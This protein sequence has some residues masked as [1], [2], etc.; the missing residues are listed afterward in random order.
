[1]AKTVTIP[2]GDNPFICKIND[3]YY[4]YPAGAT[5]EVPDEVAALI[6][7]N[8]GNR[9]K[10]NGLSDIAIPRD[11]NVD[12][13]LT[14]TADGAAWATP[15]SGSSLPT[16]T[17]DD[18]GDVL[19]VVEGAWA[20]ASGGG[21]GGDSLK[22][23]FDENGVSD[24]TWQQASDALAAGKRIYNINADAESGFVEQ[25]IWLMAYPVEG[26]ANYLYGLYCGEDSIESQVCQADTA[27]GYLYFP[28]D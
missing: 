4:S 27:D 23:T 14:R 22:I 11:G 6:Q 17:A 5:V 24:T 19:T 12:D 18:N 8:A 7:A 15:S 3:V 9:E 20:A 21:G 25:G 10:S 26:E 13:V 28:H 16:V 1:M 2:A